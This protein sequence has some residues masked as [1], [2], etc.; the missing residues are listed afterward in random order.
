V[1]FQVTVR[2]DDIHRVYSP[3]RRLASVDTLRCYC[4]CVTAAPPTSGSGARS[5]I[6]AA[7][8]GLGLS[9]LFTDFLRRRVPA[10]SYL[11]DEC[12]VIFRPLGF[13]VADDFLSRAPP[14]PADLAAVLDSLADRKRLGR[15]ARGQQGVTRVAIEVTRACDELSGRLLKT[16]GYDSSAVGIANGD[17]GTTG[18][19]S[20]N[21]K[22]LSLVQSTDETITDVWCVTDPSTGKEA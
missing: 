6:P 12:D 14:R 3:L 18:N 19:E 4:A 8:A 11:R 2:Y 1:H 9:T 15:G 7:T 16:N 10:E 5:P 17:A 21:A 13:A 22:A 20:R